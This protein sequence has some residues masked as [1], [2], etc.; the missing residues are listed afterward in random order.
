M[1]RYTNPYLKNTY[2]RWR[3]TFLKTYNFLKALTSSLLWTVSCPNE[4]SKSWFTK[5]LFEQ[6][7]G[8]LQCKTHNSLI[9]V[10]PIIL[11]RELPMYKLPNKGWRREKETKG[12]QV[13]IVNSRARWLS[14]RDRSRWPESCSSEVNCFWGEQQSVG[15]WTVFPLWNLLS[16]QSVMSALVQPPWGLNQVKPEFTI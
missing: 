2:I 16:E 12:G 3:L 6:G 1:Q 15:I 14:I 9:S 13:G 7:F 5:I 4:Q 8:C 10:S 11:W